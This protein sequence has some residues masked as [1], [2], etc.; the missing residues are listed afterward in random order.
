M[1]RNTRTAA[2]ALTG[3][4]AAHLVARQALELVAHYARAW[5]K[6]RSRD[7]LDFDD[8]D[9]YCD[10]AIQ[11]VEQE[12]NRLRAD[13]PPLADFD[14]AWYRMAAPVHLALKSYSKPEDTFGKLLW[15]LAKHVEHLPSLWEIIG[16]DY[17]QAPMPGTQPN[18]SG[19]THD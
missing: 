5:D 13:P 19:G 7:D 10:F 6:A 3:E 4:A 11:L 18:E 15:R 8:A 2:P 17:L 16:N 12:V 14:W 1:S 9:V